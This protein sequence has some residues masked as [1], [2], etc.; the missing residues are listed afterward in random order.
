VQIIVGPERKK[1]NLSKPMLAH[2]SPYF[3]KAFNGKFDEATT[4]VLVLPHATVQAFELATTF[5]FNFENRFVRF[6]CRDFE[7][8][9]GFITAMIELSALSQHLLMPS[10]DKCA[11]LNL[12]ILLDPNPANTLS[13]KHIILAFEILRMPPTLATP[14]YEPL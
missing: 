2:A 7:S 5:I 12:K 11:T 3:D 9:G 4:G 8:E 14:W 6:D 13:S 1:F 10:L